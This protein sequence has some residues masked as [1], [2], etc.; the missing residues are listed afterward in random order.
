MCDKNTPIDV[1]PATRINA[2]MRT[3]HSLEGKKVWIRFSS[4][5][6]GYE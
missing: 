5:N 1:I 3:A 4:S 6:S 2:G